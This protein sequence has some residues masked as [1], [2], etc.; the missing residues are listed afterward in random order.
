MTQR[1]LITGAA[2]LIGGILRR[3]L[4]SAY[5]LDEIDV[6]RH[7]ML[8]TKGQDMTNL[9]S[10]ERAFADHDFVVDLAANASPTANWDA[11]YGNN[12]LATFNAFEASRRAG[13]GRVIF[14][15]SNHVTGLYEH[16]DPYAAIVAGRY[17]GL[18]PAE[19]PRLTTQVAIRPDGLYAV[20][21]AFGEALGRMYAENFGISVICLRIGTVNARD[22]P[23]KSRHF[24]TLL[25]HADLIR[26]VRSAIES[27]RDLRFG[28]YYGVSNN[29][30]RFWDIDEARE[31][32]G[33]E[34]QDN[35]E[36]W[37]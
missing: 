18:E 29:T 36:Q 24:A 12:L 1:V 32:I 35:A 6:Q 15:S 8:R 7:G 20:G 25:T 19:I 27:P 34:P 3:G 33:Y 31:A 30:W 13:V 14:A 22:R 26:L 21:K 28:I 37:R 4:G 17:E 5:E 11:I 16:D 23:R 2:G 10:V 9:A